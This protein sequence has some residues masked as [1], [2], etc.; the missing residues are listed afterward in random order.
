MG[1]SIRDVLL[2]DGRTASV[3]VEGDRIAE[4]GRPRE[5]DVTIDGRGKAL[6]P[7]F[8]NTHTHAAM[9]LFRGYADDMDLQRWL[10][11][12]I[13]PAEAR[14]TPEA[15]YWG[16]K[17]A[18]LE[19]LRSGTTCFNDMYFHMDMAAKAVDEVGLR[20]VLSEGFIDLSD[21][22]RA[23]REFRQTRTVLAKIRGLRSPR[24][25]PALGPHS[26]YTVSE[27]SLR[28]LRTMA[29]SE[30]L[31][32]HIHLSETRAEVD[33]VKKERGMPPASYLDSIGFLG[34]DVV[35]AHGC[36]LDDLE[37]RRLAQQGV[38]VAHCPVSNMKLAT[39]RAMPLA[40][41][42]DAGLTLS[43]GTDGD[44]SNNS[45]DMFE[46]MKITALLHKFAA[47]DARAAPA[48]AV[49]EM[50]TAGGAR[51]LGLEAG[52]VAVG[53][54]ADLVLIDLRRPGLTPTHD[55]VSNLV[56]AG[57]GDCV[58]T[59]ICDGRVLMRDRVVRGEAEVL[60]HASAIA[61][62]LAGA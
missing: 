13:W 54:L 21:P 47:S 18:C 32:I 51:A 16:T 57:R 8:V 41:M 27:P 52:E 43:L 7:G 45:L 49:F 10:S 33:D 39:G 31:P 23:E 61:A 6:L 58:E 2:P 46:T 24:V 55:L 26:V 36:W 53:K 5:A 22:A 3:T 62:K 19:M 56:Y 40:A 38:A 35:A 60:E 37:I 42:R 17:L 12:K 50:A 1:I 30:H 59:V 48:R 28:E 25:R 20:A 11:T 14:L 44:A 29:S 9:T 15:V 34:P 4:I